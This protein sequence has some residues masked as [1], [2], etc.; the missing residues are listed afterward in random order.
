[1]RKGI[2]AGDRRKLLPHVMRALILILLGMLTFVLGLRL[3]AQRNSSIAAASKCAKC[4]LAASCG[5]SV[6]DSKEK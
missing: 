2:A 1:M 5:K 3:L 6:D 4:P